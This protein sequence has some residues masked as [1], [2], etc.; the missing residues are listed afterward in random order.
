MGVQSV[1]AAEVSTPSRWIGRVD[2]DRHEFGWPG[3]GIEIGFQGKSLILTLEDTGKNSLVVDIDGAISRLDLSS[4]SRPYRIAEDLPHGQHLVRLTRRTEGMFGDTRFISAETDGTFFN[5]TP[6]SRQLL[7]IGDSIS[8]G[9]GVEAEDKGCKSG[10]NAENQY[11]TYAAIA[12]RT[13]GADVTTLAISGIGVSRN[14]SGTGETMAA[15]IDRPTPSKT[16][17]V[18]ANSP[19]GF[20]GVVVNLG[21]ND[22]GGGQ[23]PPAFVDDY[24]SLLAR[25]RDQHPQALIY[26]ALGPMLSDADFAAAETAVKAA[27]ELRT[28]AGDAR[29]QYLRLRVNSQNFG[30]DWH[31]SPSTHAA[32]AEILTQTLRRD[33]NWSA[34]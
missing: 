29:L 34:P 3:S 24:T 2:V 7:V 16:A 31:P 1:P 26:A 14:G 9:Y 22:F 27:V 4:G 25:L 20:Q 33:L 13:L 32:L 23:R 12:G 18:T 19:Q 28:T 30:C 11:L 6:P 21:T 5:V 17:A 8:A 15:F 10:A